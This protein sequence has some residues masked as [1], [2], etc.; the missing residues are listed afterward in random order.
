MNFV[1]PMAG[2]G[3]R[4]AEAGYAL[5]K[6]L[7]QAHGKTLLEWSLES[8]PLELASTVVFVGLQ[9]HETKFNL[10]DQ[11]TKLYPNL[12]CEFI[13]LPQVT[14]GQAETV[15]LALEK[16]NHEEQLVIFNIDT[17]FQSETLAGYLLDPNNDGVL[18]CF[19]STENRFSFA[20]TNSN[21]QYVIEV[22][23][24]EVISSHALTGLYTFK[25]VADFIETYTYHNQNNLTVKG[26]LYI[27]PMYNY[28]IDKGNKYLLDIASKHYILGTPQEY[29]HF[30][31]LKDW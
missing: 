1:I 22:K 12:N 11:I 18:N 8:L 26:E 19:E 17:Y 7:L 5:P 15:F 29:E 6:M 28:L 2:H 25:K 4:F 20:K 30:L 16:C 13:F 24:K 10:S 14:R 21:N 23:E 9:E 3:S 27:A 31:S